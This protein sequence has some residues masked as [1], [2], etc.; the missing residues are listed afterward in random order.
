MKPVDEKDKIHTAALRLLKYRDRSVA[1]LRERL[2]RKGFNP[3]SVENELQ[4]L[5]DN[6]FLNDQ[7]FTEIWIRHKLTISRKGKKIIRAELAAKG[8][9]SRLFLEVWSKYRDAEIASAR[10]FTLAKAAG[11]NL[12]DSFKRRGKLRQALYR[13][14][15]SAK[16]I[17]EALKEIQ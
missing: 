3:E 12:L 4:T 10:A 2:R 7:R 8:I 5:L 6:N 11:F 14:G 15:Y 16:A 13:R 9:S 17:E 1:E